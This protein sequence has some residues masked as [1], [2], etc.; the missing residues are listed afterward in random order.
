M[1]IGFNPQ[2]DKKLHPSDF[3]HQVVVPVYIPNQ[4]GY[5]K[6]SF[7]ILKLCLD[8]L[9]R[10]SHKKTYFTVVNN[11]SC[12]EVRAYLDHL[13]Q[14]KKIHEV[15]HTIT[16]GKLNAI[17]KGLTGNQFT[18]IT[19]ADADVLFVNNWQEETYAVF[20]AFPKTG[21]VSPCPNSKLLK[22]CTTNIFFEK[23]ISESLRFR[24]V[25]NPKAMKSF[26]GS[27]GN[28]TLFNK[29]HLKKYLTVSNNDVHA[30]VG[31]GHFVGTY[32]S[33][34]FQKLRHSYSV[35]KLGGES[36][37]E[38]LDKPVSYQGYWRLSTEDNYAY[39][40]GNTF[41]DWMSKHVEDLKRNNFVYDKAPHLSKVKSNAFVNW[42]KIKVFSRILFRKSFWMLFLRY[43]GLTK[44]EAKE[45]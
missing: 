5:F 6:D 41:E 31:A 10:T 13:F 15:V 35:F 20:E 42:I 29:H 37:S 21:S 19:I 4:K 38:L 22:Y 25:K 43:K 33:D 39:H 36:E 28:P 32:R 9:F 8:S 11:G 27:I 44:S 12:D 40:M 26:A 16:I 30:V 3:F 34:V 1:R 24:N 7:S 14:N 17:L 18:L 2:K 45:Y 23:L